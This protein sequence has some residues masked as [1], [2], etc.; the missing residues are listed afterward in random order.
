MV[1]GIVAFR[2]AQKQERSARDSDRL[3]GLYDRRLQRVQ[4]E[5]M[6]KGDP[7]LDLQIA[8]HLSAR[9]LDLF[10]KGSLFEL[11]CDVETPSGR[12]ALA[13]W[14]QKPASPEEVVL[15]QQAILLLRDRTDLREKFA[16][17]REGEASQFSWDSLSGWLVAS[18][19][20]F[21]RLLSW[22][23]FRLSLSMGV[24][25]VCGWEGVVQPHY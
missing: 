18:P 7:G 8:G 14:L 24:V 11:L 23:A 3:I 16:L 17:Q 25:A 20:R 15:R 12:E 4:H 13:E 21:P 5:W 22:A 1:A 10:G 19:V 2:E 9:D 6:G